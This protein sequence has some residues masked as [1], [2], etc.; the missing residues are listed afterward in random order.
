[1]ATKKSPDAKYSK[2]LSKVDY[3]HE[4]A[5]Q[6]ALVLNEITTLEARATQLRQIVEENGELV[7]F[8]WRTSTGETIAIHKLEDDHLNNLML[9]LLRTG[10][11][12]PRSIRG[13]AVS[14]ELVIPSSVPLDWEDNA[15]KKL[16]AKFDRGDV[17]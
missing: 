15:M 6:L 16:N 8:I 3:D 14:R 5:E 4:A 9:H 12:I 7:P 10:R 1:M 11:P 17:V 2:L 13:E